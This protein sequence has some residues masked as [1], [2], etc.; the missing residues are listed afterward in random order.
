MRTSVLLLTLFLG[1]CDSLQTLKSFFQARPVDDNTALEID[2]EPHLGG[3]LKGS[4]EV[5]GAVVSAQTPHIE[6]P[7]SP[8]KHTVRVQVPGYISQEVDVDAKEGVT[9]PIAL[10]LR[11][12]PLPEG[13]KHAPDGSET[14]LGSGGGKKKKGE[15]PDK[16]GPDAKDPDD[17]EDKELAG[18]STRTFIVTATPP[19][20]ASL[21]GAALGNASGL[22]VQ[23]VTSSGELVIGDSSFG[24]TFTIVNKRSGIRMKVKNLGQ[25]SVVV[26]GSPLSAKKN[27]FDLDTRPKRLELVDVDNNKLVLLMKLVE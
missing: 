5:D 6:K 20:P 11:K 1:G 27:G 8:G 7:I 14:K 25:R 19:L 17:P 13:A 24:V 12:M 23:L 22:R 26:D 9:T 16:D 3:A 2:T 10:A 15:A 21:N 4:V 18:H